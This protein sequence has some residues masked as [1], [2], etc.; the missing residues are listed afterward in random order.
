[1]NNNINLILKSSTYPDNPPSPEILVDSKIREL[2]RKLSADNPRILLEGP[3][4]S[5][6]TVTLAQ[7][8]RNNSDCSISYFLSDNFWI[9]RQSNF[10]TSLC[11]Q[12]SALLGRDF[13]DKDLRGNEFEIDVERLKILFETL[14]QRIIELARKRKSNYYFVIDGLDWS[15]S[16]N[17]DERIIDLFPLPCHQRGL[18]FLGS[19]RNSSVLNH[20]V[21]YSK[22]EPHYFS[23]L[24]AANYLEMLEPTNEQIAKIQEIS[25]GMPGYLHVMKKLVLNNKAS[26]SQLI[27]EPAEI[28]ALMDYQW[29]DILGEL[30]TNNKLIL[31]LMAFSI[32]PLDIQTISDVL[33]IKK[34]EVEKFI[35]TAGIFIKGTDESYNFFPD[36]HKAMAQFRLQSYKEIIVSKLIIYYEN[37]SSDKSVRFLL[38]EYYIISENY[39]ALQG[40]ITPNYLVETII[41][42]K[43]LKSAQRDLVNAVDLAKKRN[44]LGVFQYG[45]S[46]SQ[47]RSLSHQ[48]IGMSEVQAL[49]SMK[50]YDDALEL[51]YSAKMVPL[52]IRLLA[53]TYLSMED[54]GMATVIA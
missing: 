48:I 26:L 35:S 2:K 34:S 20:Y 46:S 31:A 4:G 16:G 30:D 39:E 53:Q 32:I 13:F 29:R 51:A 3:I 10:L 52:R 37:I 7:F 42:N 15:F 49:V 17:Q 33:E 27:N 36:F 28:D 38:S 47:L 50:R 24:E 19:I 18:F 45:L 21:D 5:G 25:G 22:E 41:D 14:T 54:E 23:S 9:L 8:V 40:L 6:K 44:D 11:S 12:M 1:M 43:D